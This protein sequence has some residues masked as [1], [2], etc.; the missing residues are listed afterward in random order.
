MRENPDK[1]TE[2]IFTQN[3]RR[4]SIKGKLRVHTIHSDRLAHKLEIPTVSYN[5]TSH[6]MIQSTF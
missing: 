1:T 5:A 3:T 6:N 2:T 4:N